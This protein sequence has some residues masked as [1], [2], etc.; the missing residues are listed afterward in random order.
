MNEDN[1]ERPNESSK[2]EKR[3]SK[4]HLPKPLTEF[5][6]SNT[7]RLGYQSQCKTCKLSA[8][9][10]DA[11]KASHKK[12]RDTHKPAITAYK[13]KR[14]PTNKLNQRIWHYKTYFHITLEELQKILDYQ[15]GCCA[16]CGKSLS[17]PHLDHRHTDGLL[18]GA[19][20]WFCNRVLGLVRD[21]PKLLQRGAEYL[22]NPPATRALGAP[23]YGLP[24]RVGTK[25]QR[26]L[27]KKLSKQQK[28]LDTSPEIE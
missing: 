11:R 27:A 25:K 6:R 9:T 24:G 13:Q 10:S 2:N 15:S 22:M 3:C 16:M 21:D 23:R 20:C 1:G 26:K 14:A 12:Y 19:L 4:C 18:R 5:H 17:K 7:R 8:E 28:A